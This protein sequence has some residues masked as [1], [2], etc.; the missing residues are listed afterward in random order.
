MSP[1]QIAKLKKGGKISSGDVDL[2]KEAPK[3]KILGAAKGFL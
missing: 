3:P 2:E 1:Q